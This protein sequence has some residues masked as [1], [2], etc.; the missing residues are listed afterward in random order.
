VIYFILSEDRMLQSWIKSAKSIATTTSVENKNPVISNLSHSNIDELPP[1]TSKQ[2]NVSN[3]NGDN[4]IFDHSHRNGRHYISCIPCSKHP[5]INKIYSKTLPA[6]AQ[7]SGTIYREDVKKKHLISDGHIVCAKA[8]RL[9]SLSSSEVLNDKSSAMGLAL[10]KANN[11]FA[12]KIGNCMIHVYNDAKKLTLSGYSFPGRVVVSRYASNFQMNSTDSEISNTDLQYLSPNGHRN[13]LEC[14]ANTDKSRVIDTIL[15]KTLAISL[16]C[17]GS[18]DRMQVDKIYV[19]A[20]I[21][22]NEGSSELLFLGA[23]EP[24]ER[25]VKGM[26][27]AIEDG[28]DKLYGKSSFKQIISKSS[29]IVTDGAKCNTGEKNG[30]WTLLKK[31]RQE[32]DDENNEGKTSIPP[33]MTI[34]C[35]AH[36]SNLAWKSV[37]ESVR[38]LKHIIVELVAISS[39]FHTSGLRTRELKSLAQEN[40]L[41]LLRLPKLF[42]VRWS[43]FTYELLNSILT[44]WN[45]LVL[46]FMKSTEKSTIGFKKFLTNYDNLCIIA[47][48]ADLLFLFSI[49]QKKLQSDS[50]TITDMDKLITNVLKQIELLKTQNLLGGWLYTLE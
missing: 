16:R 10:S 24:K 32:S 43:E 50:L 20:K 21:I 47:S 18:V 39:F 19:L 28:C 41:S 31:M 33:L 34:W 36:R 2:F 37:S 44:S 45:V 22:N 9:S 5:N 26:I 15:N 11:D 12:S 38:E 49:Y 4:D 27:Q 46:Y 8:H 29:S 42:E 14:I 23:E 13:F 40:N 17:D 6:I 30:L 35:V 7:I 25:G 48:T 1:S 3:L